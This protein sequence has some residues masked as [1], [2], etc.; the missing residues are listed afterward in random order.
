MVHIF[1]LN[2][3]KVPAVPKGTDWRDYAGDT[4]TPLYGV[5]VPDGIIILDLD[6][7]KPRKDGS[8]VSTDEVET[9]LGCK[10]DWAGAELQTTLNGGTHYAFSVPSGLSMKNGTDVLGVVGL[11]TRA[12]GKGYIATGEGYTPA[13]F[14]DV[15]DALSEPGLFPPLPPEALAKLQD[16]YKN[17]VDSNA[18]SALGL[19]LDIAIA[20]QPLDI[21]RDEVQAYASMLTADHA[22]DDWLAVMQAIHHQSG[23]AE[24]GWEIADAFSRKCPA[25]YDKRGNRKR[26]ESFGKTPR[27][28]PITFASIIKMVGPIRV[29]PA[30]DTALTLRQEA[31]SVS[32]MESYSAFKSRVTALS[33]VQLPQDIRSVLASEVHKAFGKAEG[34]GLR[35][36]KSALAP[37]KGK[38]LSKSAPD[39]P[40]W[41]SDWVYV[42]A[43]CLFVNTKVGQYAIRR[44][45]FRARFDRMAEVVALETD[46]ATYAL[47]I[48]Q[49]PTVLRGMYW[50]GQERI[51]ETEGAE[52]V[53]TYHPSGIAPCDAMDEDGQAAVDLFL[54]HVANTI[55]DEREQAILLDFMA[56]V[57]RNPGRRVHWGLLLWGIEGNGKT[58]FFKIMQ[59]LLGQNAKVITTS[60]VERPFTD[61]A[62]GARLVG[63]EEVRISGTNKWR[64]LDQIKPMITNDTIGVEPKG[65]T[66]YQAPNFSSYLMTT[67]HMD[68]VPVSDNDRRYCA[69]FTRHRVQQDLFDQHG[70]AEGAAEYFRRLFVES[71]RRVDAI[72]RYLMD[73]Q[74]SE[75]FDPQGRAPITEGVAIMRE[76]NITDERALIED[77]IEEH[78]CEI[79]GPTLLD[80][81]HLGDLALMGDDG[82][83]LP[84]GRALAN[85]LR[86]MGY[87]PIDGRRVKLK[88]RKYHYVWFRAANGLTGDSARK[89]VRQWHEGD[90]DFSDVPF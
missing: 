14:V 53:N 47:N 75:E 65:G 77:L 40:D 4:T 24:W 23:G 49:I 19:D 69:I 46:A 16:S 80:V 25:K 37:P 52:Y 90:D 74:I 73:R 42:E 33:A 29:S 26:W 18:A 43:D 68:A 50:P 81:T 89:T 35:D 85:I 13:T 44:E 62:V 63:I 72:G 41:L 27:T 22:A 39:L 31:E 38:R 2:Q 59:L 70:G 66:V 60:M 8:L 48:A 36:I 86:D 54:A 3:R 11:D 7:Y 82:D 6:T 17:G 61:W 51:F 32:D 79:I 83:M 5:A 58:Y 57:Y 1:P 15:E 45:G 20:S 56:Y 84:Q 55:E 10:L 9:A 71:E 34:M 28:N 64:V 87:Q 76:A 21:S 67:N 78:A 30:S 12:A 88:S